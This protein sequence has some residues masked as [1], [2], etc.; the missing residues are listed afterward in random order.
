VLPPVIEIRVPAPASVPADRAE[1]VCVTLTPSLHTDDVALGVGDYTSRCESDEL[2]TRACL[3]MEAGAQWPRRF[4][5][6]VCQAPEHELHVAFVRG[7]EPFDD[8]LDGVTLVRMVGP[9]VL[10]KDQYARFSVPGWADAPGILPGGECEVRDGWLRVF[11]RQRE[12]LSTYTCTIVP[13]EA[14]AAEIEV[15]IRLVVRLR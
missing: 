13:Q 1:E 15:P 12:D 3:R 5:L 10:S 11:F 2:A 4:P 8:P 9:D 6:L 14:G 7:Y